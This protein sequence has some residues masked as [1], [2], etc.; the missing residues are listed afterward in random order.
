MSA[1]PAVTFMGQA[2]GDTDLD[3]S[4]RISN[5]YQTP[6]LLCQ[7]PEHPGGSPG[8]SDVAVRTCREPPARAGLRDRPGKAAPPGWLCRAPPPRHRG[9]PPGAGRGTERLEWGQPHHF[10]HPRGDVVSYFYLWPRR[11]EEWMEAR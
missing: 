2:S 8:G 7:L 5:G 10:T 6:Q 3:R 11:G 1:V 4:A 9:T